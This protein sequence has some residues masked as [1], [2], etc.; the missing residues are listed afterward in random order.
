[1]NFTVLTIF[2]SMFDSFRTHGIL[3]RALELK[4]ISVACIDIREHAAGRHRVTDDRPYGGGPG[5]VMKPEPLAAAIRAAS[6]LQ[7]QARTILLTPRG[8]K[9][10]QVI[11]AELASI[12]ALNLVCGRYE[13]VDERIDHDLIDDELSIG[14]YV[15]SGGEP[16][17]MVV[18]DAVT[19]LVPGVLGGE[20]SADR[21]SFSDGLLEHSHY[22]RP[23]EF[24]GKKVP[25]VLFSGHHRRIDQWRLRSSL[26]RTFMNRPEL[27]HQRELSR[28]ELEILKSWSEELAALL[29]P[30]KER[31]Y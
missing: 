14:D 5:M 16:A 11:A 6:L 8:R 20:D 21:D 27:L 30:Q 31:R 22:T 4:R 9:L 12:E 10:D 7:P 24:E 19:R 23:R 3:R 1:M 25:E 17:A 28:A 26:L 18:M 13:G 15:L 29:K 2:P